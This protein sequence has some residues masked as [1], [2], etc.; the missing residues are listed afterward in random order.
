MTRIVFTWL[1][2]ILVTPWSQADVID[3]GNIVFIGDS[4]S[5]GA[6]YRPV[7]EG[8]RSW[9]YSFWQN[10]IDNGDTFQFV[11]SRTSNEA[12]SSSYPVYN[13]RT[14]ENRHEAIWGTTSFERAATLAPQYS[15]LNADGSNRAADTAFLFLGSNDASDPAYALTTIRDQF[16]LIIDGLQIANSD[17]NIQLISVLPRF[18][19]D[20]NGDGFAD[21]PYSRNPEY[22]ALNA[23]LSDL[24]TEE[25][26]S[27]SSVGFIDVASHMTPPLSYDGLHPNGA[28]E[29]FV[30]DFIYT[31]TANSMASAPEP[32]SLLLLCGMSVVLTIGYFRRRRQPA[33]AHSQQA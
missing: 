7:G 33:R 28:G 14:F 19:D 3:F 23:L 17:V 25:T 26:T 12:G 9:R 1:L 5:E 24:A 11:G 27:T 32:S 31:A 6:S 21:S 29:D 22:A 30:G 4:I 16:G 10:I 18:I 2:T 8:D 15:D 20:T 13:S